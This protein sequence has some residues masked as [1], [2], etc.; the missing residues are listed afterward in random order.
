MASWH[1]S[2]DLSDQ[3]ENEALAEPSTPLHRH[4]K[5]LKI[6]ETCLKA[7]CLKLRWHSTKAQDPELVVIEA[8]GS[9]R[10]ADDHPCLTAPGYPRRG[11]LIGLTLDPKP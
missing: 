8:D 9:I 6:C 4:A 11:A 10:S 5:A 1:V 3:E 7:H 2:P